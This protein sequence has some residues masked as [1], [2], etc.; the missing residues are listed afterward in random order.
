MKNSETKT[1]NQRFVCQNDGRI[2]PDSVH[3][4]FRKP[5]ESSV[6]LCAGFAVHLNSFSALES[7]E[8]IPKL[9]LHSGHPIINSFA[10]GTFS[11]DYPSAYFWS[12]HF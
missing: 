7:V 5:L 9:M 1:K 4:D 8:F 12:C 6:Y 11:A 10:M 3:R 2:V